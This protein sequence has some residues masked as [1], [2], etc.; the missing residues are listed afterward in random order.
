MIQAQTRQL[1]KHQLSDL[2]LREWQKYR[3]WKLRILEELEHSGGMTT[4]EISTRIGYGAARTTDTLCKMLRSGLVEK[5][6]GWG[7]RITR[8]GVFL[9]N[10]NYTATIQPQH[11]HNTATIQPEEK[12][13]PAPKCF[14]SPTCHIKRAYTKE[15][16][17]TKTS[18][19]CLNCV[20]YRPEQWNIA[21]FPLEKKPMGSTG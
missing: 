9:I 5:I 6:E 3:G 17:T 19:L 1:S 21:P 15:G 12:S 4:R 8:D 7:W 11:S 2:S 20:W 13:E 16:Y 14:Q 18:M 10:I